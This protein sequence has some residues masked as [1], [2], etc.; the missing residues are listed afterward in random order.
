MT[1]DSALARELADLLASR[2]EYHDLEPPGM[3]IR[4]TE[5]DEII[6]LL[7]TGTWGLK[8]RCCVCGGVTQSDAHAIA[9][10]RAREGR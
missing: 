2:G 10:N 9:C 5:R 6:R 1:T 3:Y 4:L 8:D 7:R